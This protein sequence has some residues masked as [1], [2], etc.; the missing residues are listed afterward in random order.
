LRGR[1]EHL[2]SRAV[3]D[4]E[5]LGEKA[6]RA[7][8]E[9]GVIEDE[10]DLFLLT[11]DKLQASDFFVKG[12]D[13]ELAEN[14]KLLL[15][16]LEVAR[17]KP[18]WRIIAAMSMRHVGPPTAQALARAFPS[19]DAI[20]KAKPEDFAEVEGIGAV[21]AQSIVEWFSEQW[22]R[23]II[24]KW[25]AGG[26]ALESTQTE[27]GPQTL[28]GLSVVVTGTLDGFS[29]EGASEAITSRGG[30]SASSVSAKTDFV[31]IGPG[32]GSKAAKAQEL[33][34]PILDE[35]GFVLLLEQGADAALAY[36]AELA[37]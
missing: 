26:L 23:D 3:L 10:G 16:E 19:I 5:G 7:L 12:A 4:I 30:K 22:H 24:E 27:S 2:G 29:R 11:E 21:I 37:K 8:L 25:R 33:G 28:A 32:A 6:A 9:D 1:L 36:A 17:T 34:R 18:L 35:A 15:A 13:R 14:A 31:V 20:A